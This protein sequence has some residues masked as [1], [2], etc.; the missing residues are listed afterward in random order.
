M[1]ACAAPQGYSRTLEE[2][3]GA[4]GA[5]VI[6]ADIA[7]ATL[8]NLPIVGRVLSTLRT[9]YSRAEARGDIETL[10]NELDEIITEL[11]GLMAQHSTDS[12]VH[13]FLEKTCE[14]VEQSLH[15]GWRERAEEAL[16][17][18]DAKERLVDALRLATSRYVRLDV[19]LALQGRQLVTQQTV[20]AIA[21]EDLQ[22]HAG[23][24]PPIGRGQFTVWSGSLRRRGKKEGFKAVAVK[25]YPALGLSRA[26][27]K[28]TV[29]KLK[30]TV[31][32]NARLQMECKSRN[33]L[34]I[35][36]VCHGHG[37][38]KSS[39]LLLTPLL[40][41]GSL[42][43][44][45]SPAEGET[46]QR[47]AQRLLLDAKRKDVLASVL[48]GIAAG[49]H[50]MHSREPA[51]AHRDIKSAN[52]LLRHTQSLEGPSLEAVLHDFDLA[53]EFQK[54]RTTMTL[55]ST[56]GRGSVGGT[57]QYMAPERFAQTEEL[58]AAKPARHD[59]YATQTP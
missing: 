27:L 1:G 25:E 5:L 32:K 14:I 15:R 21:A 43:K 9:V 46:A 58:P 37:H 50:H 13:R 57:P 40:P 56:A 23:D 44:I 51:V 55:T 4:E 39:V 8:Q 19:Q 31:R 30:E 7:G 33:I 16:S 18:E 42:D 38:C 35:L 6:G 26:E 10:A 59:L 45:I 17:P 53:T 36:G 49:L 29:R 24:T 22:V 3:Y 2:V 52:V 11:S 41:L 28:E 48:Y 20:P 12:E 54:Y 47:E 34:P